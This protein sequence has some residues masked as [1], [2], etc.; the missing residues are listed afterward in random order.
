MKNYLRKSRIFASVHHRSKWNSLNYYTGWLPLIG[1]AVLSFMSFRLS[2]QQNYWVLGNQLVSFAETG[3]EVSA[4]PVPGSNVNLHYTGNLPQ[5]NQM[6]QYSS[7]GDL[8]FFII[9]GVIYDNDGFVIAKNLG[10]L[11][12]DISLNDEGKSFLYSSVLQSE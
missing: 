11:S 10:D 2:A 9:D 12:A 3:I 1:I 8:L 5:K 4:L 6:A 7:T